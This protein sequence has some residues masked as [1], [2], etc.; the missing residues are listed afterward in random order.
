MLLK[1]QLYLAKFDDIQNI[2]LENLKALFHIVANYGDLV[3][4]SLVF[5][6]LFF[7]KTGNFRHNCFFFKLFLQNGE[8]LWPK[9]TTCIVIYFPG[10]SS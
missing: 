6:W 5:L 4:Q 3:N 1:W 9:K 7:E 2:K 10:I 8:N